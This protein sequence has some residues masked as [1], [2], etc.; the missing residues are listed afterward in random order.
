METRRVVI[1]GMGVISPLGL[2]VPTMWQNLI[3]GKSGIGPITLFDTTDLG[4]TIA[5]EAHGFDPLNYMSAKDARRADRF[6]HFAIAALE[7]ALAQSGLEVNS[8][9]AYDIGVVV[10]SGIGGIATYTVELDNLRENGPR[11]VSPLLVPMI[12]IDVASVQIA[13]RTGAQGPNLGVASACATGADS[14]GLAFETIRRGDAK[15]MFAGSV[16]AAVTPIGMA[17]FDRMRAISRRN[18]EPEKASRPF[19]VD[20]DG[21]VLAEGGAVLLL[22]DL[23]FALARGAEPLAE[24]IGYA[25]TSDAVH[26]TAPDADGASAA[27]CMRLAMKRA[28]VAPAE[29]SYINAHGTSTPL[30]DPA[31]TAAIK[32][33]MGDQAYRVPI[34]SAKSMTGHLSAGSGSLEAAICVQAIRN[35][36][37]PPTINLDTPDPA[38]D[39]D[40]VPHHTRQ[41]QVDIAMSNSFGFGGHNA[42]IILKTYN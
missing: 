9:N 5:G 36:L 21:F 25:A 4:V 37:I 15:A 40:F 27:R 6:T 42:V 2:D 1:T 23:D 34:S 22:E 33:A 32:R 17:T 18:D 30:G 16:E 20:R 8:H 28:G 7:E 24:M 39:L 10:G 35:N 26:I 19:D 12:T 13:L 29:V 41:A 38:C 3:E 14:M 31:E 11:R